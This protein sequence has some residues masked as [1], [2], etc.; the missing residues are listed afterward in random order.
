MSH[1]QRIVDIVYFDAGSGHRSS[2]L[3]LE[4]VLRDARPGWRV[5]MVNA[6]ELFAVHPRFHRILRMGI[7]YFNGMLRRER[8]F[9]LKGL[10]N[11]SLLCHDLLT[12]Q[13]LAQIARFWAGRE[14]DAVVSVTPMYNPAI[15]RSA[16]H[17]NPHTTCITIP[18]DFE[19]AKA[20]YWFTPRVAQ[21]YLLGSDRLQEQGRQAGVPDTLLH[22]LPGFIV[23]PGLYAGAEPDRAA[24]LA[25]L[26]LDPH[27]PTGVLSFGGQG[28]LVMVELARRLADEGLPLNMIF[29]CGRSEGVR[30]AL[31][32]LVTPYRKAVLGYV[33]ETPLTYLRLG[34]FFIG[35]PGTMTIT[36]AL[37]LSRPLVAIKSTGMRPVQA[38]NERWLTASGVGVVVRPGQVGRA[39]RA[40][41]SDPGYVE[42][43]RRAYHCG[44]FVA[45]EQIVALV[46]AAG[47]AVAPSTGGPSGRLGGHVR[48]RC[49]PEEHTGNGAGRCEL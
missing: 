43:A 24:R 22:R 42:R 49:R 36:E 15:Y 1:P 44:V 10:I 8:V 21:H 7:G 2:A 48:P 41:L 28:S 20:R 6:E 35:K 11:L 9:D 46:E 12:P 30:A 17:A 4:R 16:R 3:A 40:V 26:G 18:V 32:R 39:V 33:P 25:A 47:M 5:R 13:D 34:E 29:L 27:L 45:A 38:G 23:D 14:P 37:T 19:E 31:D